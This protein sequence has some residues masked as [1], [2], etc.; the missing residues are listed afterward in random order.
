MQG[1]REN[2][3]PKKWYVYCSNYECIS[4]R[5]LNLAG[6]H[7]QRR[8][9]CNGDFAISVEEPRGEGHIRRYRKMVVA[10][11]SR[12]ANA[13][14]DRTCNLSSSFLG[15]CTR[16]LSKRIASILSDEQPE[17]RRNFNTASK[18]LRSMWHA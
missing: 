4:M 12:R 3:I 1:S 10:E 16:N 2:A 13:L 7:K 18:V 5:R 6:L 8:R 11:V 9:A 14:Y 15:F 17:T